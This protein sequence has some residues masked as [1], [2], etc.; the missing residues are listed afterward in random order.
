MLGIQS[1][2]SGEKSGEKIDCA[3][4]EV[5]AESIHSIQERSLLCVFVK[6]THLFNGVFLPT[7]GIGI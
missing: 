7:R 6:N 2:V 4:K 5:L 1:N 3:S